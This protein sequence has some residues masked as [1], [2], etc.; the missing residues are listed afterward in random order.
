VGCARISPERKHEIIKKK[1][2]TCFYLTF[3]KHPIING[4]R[5][6]RFNV[7]G[8]WVAYIIHN[9]RT[10]TSTHYTRYAGGYDDSVR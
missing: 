4:Q 8:E 3:L 10:D 7:Y 5:R 1:Q 6:F 9:V 2:Q